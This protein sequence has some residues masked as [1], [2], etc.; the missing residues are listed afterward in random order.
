MLWPEFS[1]ITLNWKMFRCSKE[2]NNY[3]III[4]IERFNKGYVIRVE[5]CQKH[6]SMLSSIVSQRVYF[7]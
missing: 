7:C 3:L 2:W 4:T 5:I 6:N 1:A